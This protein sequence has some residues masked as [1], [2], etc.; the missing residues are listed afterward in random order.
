MKPRLSIV[1]PTLN[2]P[3]T[4]ASCLACLNGAHEVIVVDGGSGDDSRRIAEQNGATLLPSPRGRGI[5]LRNGADAA[6]G[7]WLLFLHAD[8]LLGADWT[9]AVERH[10]ASAPD[11][12]GYFRFRLQSDAWQARL[13]ETGV[14]LRAQMFGLPYGDQ[15]LLVRRALY[16][17]IGGYRPLPLLE[18]V[19]LVCRLGRRRLR[20]LPADALTSAARWQEDGWLARSVRNIA[21]LSLYLAGVS[22]ER[23]SSF[24]AGP[25]KKARGSADLPARS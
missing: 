19:D 8:T 18:D 20:R 21:C 11:A 17:R 10:M 13:V 1:V 6:S 25:A 2:A 22:P 23:I 4:L 15:A 5:Q 9:D 14:R 12:A 24:Y 7:D 16:D 3:K